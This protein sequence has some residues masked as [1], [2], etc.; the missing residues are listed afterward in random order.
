MTPGLRPSR[1]TSTSSSRSRRRPSASE[2]YT[3]SLMEI[4][5][6][7]YQRTTLKKR[8]RPIVRALA[9]AFFGRGRPGTKLDAFVDEVDRFMSA[10]SK[11][12]RFGL[13][14]M[15]NVIELSP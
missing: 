10:T 14:L 5:T 1:Q 12:L 11:T 6:R 13:V 2:R 4:R 8:H 9:E 3:A 7:D 15:L